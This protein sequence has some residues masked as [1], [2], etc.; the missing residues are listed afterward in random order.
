MAARAYPCRDPE[1][2]KLIQERALHVSPPVPAAPALS[3]LPGHLLGSFN[4][5]LALLPGH[6][7]ASHHGG[8]HHDRASWTAGIGLLETFKSGIA[9]PQ[10][11]TAVRLAANQVPLRI[12]LA[13]A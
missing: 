7:F 8:F 9:D 3:E 13:V 1:V 5:N 6:L 12:R 11:I 4:R 10:G 2:P